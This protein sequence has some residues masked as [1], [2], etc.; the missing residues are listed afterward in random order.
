MQGFN[1]R[2][3]LMLY[4]RKGNIYAQTHYIPVHLMPYY[5]ERGWNEG[6]FPIAEKYYKR[7][8]SL[9]IY[10]TLSDNEFNYII[11]KIETFYSNNS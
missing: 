3:E 4:L 5:R 2:D 8:I 7:C 1:K 11:E 6:D 9:P 10:P